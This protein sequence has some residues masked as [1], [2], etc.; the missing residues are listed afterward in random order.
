[1]PKFRYQ[2]PIVEAVQWTGSL[3]SFHAIERMAGTG[4]VRIECDSLSIGNEMPALRVAL[5]GYAYKYPRTRVSV[6]DKEDFE[7]FFKPVEDGEG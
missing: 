3:E 6:L 2:G 7:R 5:G 1:M 4:T